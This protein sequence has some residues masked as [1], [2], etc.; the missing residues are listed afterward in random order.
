MLIAQITDTH[1]MPRGQEWLGDAETN[2]HRRLERVVIA[3]NNLKPA[4][5]IVVLTGDNI[6]GTN[7]SGAYSALKEILSEL[8]TPYYVIPGNHD[9]REGLRSVFQA[10]RDSSFVFDHSEARVIGLDSLAP[11]KDFGFL[12]N[13][14]LQFLKQSLNERRDVPALL[15]AHHFPVNVGIEVFNQM[16]LRNAEDLENIMRFYPHVIGL[17]CGHFHNQFSTLFAGKPLYISPSC[18]PNFF[19]ESADAKRASH[20]NLEPPQFSLHKISGFNFWSKVI[21]VV[22][23]ERT[24]VL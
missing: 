19:F 18:A 11:G 14:Q 22:R 8:R 15:F 6:D 24:L 20:I 5:D 7:H 12:G 16:T 4:P 10:Q 3:I 9:D 21:S 13:D 1:I 23:A 2:V 17:V